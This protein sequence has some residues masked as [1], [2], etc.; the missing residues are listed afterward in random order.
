M[1]VLE[2]FGEGLL[3]P[4]CLLQVVTD[5]LFAVRGFL[6]AVAQG[7]LLPT[8]ALLLA[9]ARLL[10]LELLKG[11]EGVHI[12]DAGLCAGLC[13]NRLSR[14]GMQ[15]IEQVVQPFPARNTSAGQHPG[16]LV[17]THSQCTCRLAPGRPC[18]VH[19]LAQP[20]NP[21]RYLAPQ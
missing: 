6:H 13:V 20:A 14:S 10:F 17:L 2:L 4:V 5:A 1:Q 3:L 21:G 15:S 11:P 12:Q 16:Q 7:V 8:R 9:L 19:E 18:L